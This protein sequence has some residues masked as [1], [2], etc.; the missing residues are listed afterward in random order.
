M[1]CQRHTHTRTHADLVHCPPG[2][3]SLQVKDCV[4]GAHKA[5]IGTPTP[6]PVSDPFTKARFSTPTSLQSTQPEL[7]SLRASG[8][9]LL[10]RPRTR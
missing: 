8:S 4:F 7:K 3:T 5:R 9:I 10:T 1:P 2:G 6:A